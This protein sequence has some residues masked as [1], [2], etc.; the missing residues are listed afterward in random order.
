[1]EIQRDLQKVFPIGQAKCR[2]SWREI[3]YSNH[4]TQLWVSRPHKAHGFKAIY[5]LRTTGKFTHKKDA[6]QPL[7]T[8]ICSKLSG[9][10]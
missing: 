3:R 2:K 5:P 9:I 4:C 1:M 8:R 7:T 6:R 10:K